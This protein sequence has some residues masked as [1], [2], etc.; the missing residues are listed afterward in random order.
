LLSDFFD[1]PQYKSIFKYSLS[2][3]RILSM[4]GIYTINGFLPSLRPGEKMAFLGFKRGLLSWDRQTLKKSKN[5]AR[6]MFEAV[7]HSQEPG[8]I[9]R[10]R[11]R[12]TEFFRENNKIKSSSV[13]IALKW[14]E[15]KLQLPRPFDK[16]GNPK[17]YEK[18]GNCPE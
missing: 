1:S 12:S 13:D 16:D 17:E 15:R 11:R 5:Q 4:V 7:Y 10:K 18:K 9:D 8:Y 14:W 6:I 3:S 2:F